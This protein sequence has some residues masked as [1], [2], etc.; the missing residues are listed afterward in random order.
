MKKEQIYQLLLC[1]KLIPVF[2]NSSVALSQQVLNASYNGGVRVFEF[3]NRGKNALEIF[4]ELIKYRNLHFPDLLMGAGTIL[5]T[6][7]AKAFIAA[8]ADFLVSPI[9]SNE[10][11]IFAKENNIVWIP[12][13]GTLT[14]I[15]NADTSG[16]LL[17]K[18]FPGGT[19]GPNFVSAVLAPMPW[20]KLMPT[21]G[22]E[23]TEVNLSAWFKAGVSC[24]GMGSQLITKE[25]LEEQNFDQLQQKITNVL[26]IISQHK[27]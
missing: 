10:L 5:N 18:I 17:I 23:P 1:E 20:L 3:T 7:S 21:G 16:C 26:S 22:V 13:C 12:G 14:E 11:M 6:D 25:I 19:L 4:K 24:V 27:K 2:Y 15:A 8:G 9:F